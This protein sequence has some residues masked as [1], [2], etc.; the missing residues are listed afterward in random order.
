MRPPALACSLAI[1]LA[2]SALAAPPAGPSSATLPAD[3][4]PPAGTTA[5]GRYPATGEQ[6]YGCIG[7]GQPGSDVSAWTLKAPEAWLTGPDGRHA[8]HHTAGPTWTANDGSAVRGKV[9]AA[10]PKPGSIPSLL[11]A[12]TATGTGMLAG[13]RF[14]QRLDT[15]GGAAPS[16]ACSKGEERRVAYTATYV[17][18]R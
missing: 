2:T 15:T 9:L 10:V 5:I 14:V 6:I 13:V 17:F 4:Q 12:A 8:I 18:W 11:L 1:L 16:G 7:N 3:L